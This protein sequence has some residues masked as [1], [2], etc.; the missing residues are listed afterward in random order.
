[1]GARGC[2]GLLAKPLARADLEDGKREFFSPDGLPS[3]KD[4]AVRTECQMSSQLK[5]SGSK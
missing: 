3:G 5:I 2:A 4:G 1:M